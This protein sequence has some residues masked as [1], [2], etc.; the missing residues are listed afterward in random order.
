MGDYNINKKYHILY[1]VTNKIND[2]YYIGIHSTN[3][4]KDNYYGSGIKI[5]YAIKKYGK[6]KFRFEIISFENSREKLFKKEKELVNEILLSDKNCMNLARGG[7][8]GD[9]SSYIGTSKY[10]KERW[11]D[12]EYR[13]KITKQLR[14]NMVNNHKLGKMKHKSFLGKKHSNETKEKI[15][16][17]SAINQKG[18]G[19]SQYGTIWITN[20]LE[21]K[22][23]KRGE[24]IPDGW[25]IGRYI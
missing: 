18:K 25:Y 14:I 24:I 23:I 3:N 2:K 6:E 9:L 7:I 10:Q 17:A 4:L 22:K 1:K 11:K 16:K 5:R 21:N 8:G 19:N 20:K 13:E 12:P 15:G